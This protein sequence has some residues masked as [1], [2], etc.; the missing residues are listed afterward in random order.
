VLDNWARVVEAV[1][2]RSPTV[3]ALLRAPAVPIALDGNFVVLGF[4][5]KS[6]FHRKKLEEPKNR[7]AV[8]QVLAE[9]LGHPYHV[10]CVAVSEDELA[11]A[12]ATR[13]PAADGAD[14]PLNP[15]ALKAR[16]IIDDEE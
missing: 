10:R 4:G 3:Q 16:A 8:E 12:Q 5:P 6:E 7:D 1:R 14:P 2:R 13:R 15:R 9:V 11:R